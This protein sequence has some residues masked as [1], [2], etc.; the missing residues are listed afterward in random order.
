MKKIIVISVAILLLLSGISITAL[1]YIGDKMVDTLLQND[2]DNLVADYATAPVNDIS[3]VS[4]DRNESDNEGSFRKE[5]AG[6]TTNLSE[7]RN[8]TA[9]DKTSDSVQ[10]GSSNEKNTSS[11]PKNEARK[12]LD[13]NIGS[14]IQFSNKQINEI[15]DKVSA[16]DKINSAALLLKRLSKSDIEELKDMLS[17]G[18]D[19]TEK[20]RAKEILY[21]R[22]TDQEIETV[23]N[24]Y[25]KYIG[26]K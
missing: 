2:F 22:L 12:P 14:Q 18:V 23:R 17:G 3:S 24:I 13:Q 19:S 11:G 26:D 5:T 9:G 15:K 16:S 21:R 25:Q 20:E 7:N 8:E 10:K 1:Y 6:E 4:I